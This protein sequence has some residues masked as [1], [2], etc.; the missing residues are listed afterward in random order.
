M[1]KVLFVCHGNGLTFPDGSTENE[2]LVNSAGQIISGQYKEIAS[3]AGWFSDNKLSSKVKV[4][5]A[6]IPDGISC[7]MD[8]YATGK[9]LSLKRAPILI[10]LF[11]PQQPLLSSLM[12]LC[13]HLRP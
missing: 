12:K 13:L 6:G 4:S 1:I 8:L 9:P 7:D 11:L 10:N 2:I 5:E 3:S